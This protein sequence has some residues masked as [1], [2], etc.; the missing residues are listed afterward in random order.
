V[1]LNLIDRL[2]EYSAGR[3]TARMTA[4]A[5]LDDLIDACETRSQENRT[6]EERIKLVNL[7]H[8][9]THNDNWIAGHLA[10]VL[11]DLQAGEQRHGIKVLLTDHKKEPGMYDMAYAVQEAYRGSHAEW[12]QVTSRMI[13]W[14]NINRKNIS[15]ITI[16]QIKLLQIQMEDPELVNK[17]RTERSVILDDILD[18]FEWILASEGHDL[19]A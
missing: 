3:W 7:V 11:L 15:A 18:R 17:T 12:D 8:D 10:T 14:Q 5:I 4:N 1:E 13:A 6:A 19:I 9:M 2:K 16:M